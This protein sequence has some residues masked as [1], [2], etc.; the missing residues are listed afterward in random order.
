[1]SFRAWFL[2]FVSVK[3]LM[4]LSIGVCILPKPIL[5]KHHSFNQSYILVDIF[6]NSSSRGL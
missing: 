1:M 5:L 4:N 6:F 2:E 3:I